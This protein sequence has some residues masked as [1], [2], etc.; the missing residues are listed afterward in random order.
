MLAHVAHA[1]AAEVEGRLRE[2]FG[3]GAARLRGLR[4]MSSGLL[5]LQWNSADVT[6][7]D[8]DLDAA[9]EFYGSLPWGLRVPI[10]IPWSTG[11]RLLRQP[12]MAL[13]AGD[14]RAAAAVP[15]LEL[16]EADDLEAVLAVDGAAFGSDPE[17]SRPWA[18][19]HMGAAGITVALAYLGAEPVATAY[20]IR[21]AGDAG[22][23]LLLAGVGVVP[24]ARRRGVGAAVSAWLLRRGF[25]TGARFAHLHADSEEA[26]RVYARLGFAGAGALDI[27]V[28]L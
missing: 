13:H 17:A 19:P 8:A 26:A 20:S 22:P 28:D 23:A 1:D 21:S 2:P 18:A 27:Y 9:R 25:A 4:A 7:S 24:A 5:A 10:G 12:L 3:G 11:R 15:G 14:L 6:D 16:R